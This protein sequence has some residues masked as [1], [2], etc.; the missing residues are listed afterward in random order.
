MKKQNNSCKL[1]NS[2]SLEKLST[3]IPQEHSLVIEGL[4][5]APKAALLQLIASATK[6][7]FS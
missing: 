3:L 1:F 5:D 4:W 7:V 2:P 6:K